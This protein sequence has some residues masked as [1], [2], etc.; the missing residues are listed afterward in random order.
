MQ[1][2]L[3]TN[4]QHCPCT[5]APGHSWAAET[6]YLPAILPELLYWQFQSIRFSSGKKWW[7]LDLLDLG[8]FYFCSQNIHSLTYIDGQTLV[9][10]QPPTPPHCTGVPMGTCSID[11]CD[12]MGSV[13]S[14]VNSPH[15]PPHPGPQSLSFT[16][17]I[18][19][20]SSTSLNPVSECDLVKLSWVSWETSFIFSVCQENFFCISTVCQSMCYELS[21]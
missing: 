4:L 13:L 8:Y 12:V 16:H 5:S 20:Y 3:V 14:S 9:H 11:K 7:I 6:L 2:F 1:A 18:T 19:Q 15:I 21:T 10:I 17:T